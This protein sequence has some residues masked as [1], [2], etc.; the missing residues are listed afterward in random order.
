MI[1]SIRNERTR[2][3]SK[4]RFGNDERAETM[5]RVK[6]GSGTKAPW[7]NPFD[8]GSNKLTHGGPHGDGARK[9]KGGRKN[10]DFFSF[11]PHCSM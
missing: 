5:K 10:R 2:K 7:V 1:K 4:N 9:E 3:V 6:T 8:H 11:V